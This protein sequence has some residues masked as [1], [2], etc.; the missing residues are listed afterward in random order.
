M[1][2]SVDAGGGG[3]G[4]GEKYRAECWNRGKVKNCRRL[5]W[6]VTM[7]LLPL[8]ECNDNNQFSIIYW[9]LKREKKHY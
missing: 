8:S 9:A 2:V 1:A 3:G 5:S 4:G 6:F 7:L